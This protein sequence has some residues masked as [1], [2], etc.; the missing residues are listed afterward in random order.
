M[1][2]LIQILVKNLKVDEQQATG[3]AAVIFKAAR[4]KLGATEF[5]SLLTKVKGVDQL[6]AKAP[7][8]GGLGKL[9]GGFASALGGGNAAILA[10]VLSG[11][12]K[13]GLT[14]QQAQQF[15][16]VITDYL[17]GTI[18]KAATDKLE[19]TLRA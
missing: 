5:A 16:P 11:F 19:K 15:V 13:L 14:Q 3:G 1:Q 2:D 4:D 12:S 17:R 6:I 9:L 8:S 7:E 18:G 10:N